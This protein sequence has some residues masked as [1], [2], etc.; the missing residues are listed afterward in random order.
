[1]SSHQ[2]EIDSHLLAMLEAGIALLQRN[3]RQ[4]IRGRPDV[5]VQN[6]QVHLDGYRF[7][8]CTFVNCTL[9]YTMPDFELVDCVFV[10][11][12]NIVPLPPDFDAGSMGS[13]EG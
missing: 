4:V 10:G 3:P 12:T 9:T 11:K 5:P 13:I 6:E 8:N 7:E 2:D 1:M